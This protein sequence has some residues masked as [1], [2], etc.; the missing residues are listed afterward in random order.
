MSTAV[1]APTSMK[2]TA[3]MESIAVK[4]TAVASTE[5]AYTTKPAVVRVTITI[6]EWIIIPIIVWII[7]PIAVWRIGIN[8]V[9]M[10]MMFFS[11]SFGYPN[12]RHDSC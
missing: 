5:P 1:T 12:K 7:I 10:V 11:V 8:M 2:S 4:S 6:I 3:T 9:V